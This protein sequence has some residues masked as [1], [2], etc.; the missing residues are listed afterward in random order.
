M[1]SREKSGTY[2]LAAKPEFEQLAVNRLGEDSSRSNACPIVSDGQILL[3]TD[4]AIY[5]IGK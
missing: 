1:G 2:V 5:C 4:K 3:R